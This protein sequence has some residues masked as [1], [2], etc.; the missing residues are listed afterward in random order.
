M[1]RKKVLSQAAKDIIL[2]NKES[3][4]RTIETAL[5]SKHE[6]LPRKA[7]KTFLKDSNIERFTYRDFD[8]K[9][10]ANYVGAW[11][12]DIIY[13]R[14]LIAKSAKERREQYPEDEYPR[15]FAIFMNT[16]SGYVFY[17][18]S[19][20]QTK[21]DLYSFEK[22][23]KH[24]LNQKF[25]KYPIVSVQSDKQSGFDNKKNYLGN[26]DVRKYKD[27]YHVIMS[28]INAFASQMRKYIYQAEGRFD[29]DN[30]PIKLSRFEEFVD[31]W[32]H[33][34]VPGMKCTRE[35][36]MK[37]E[38][39]EVLYIANALYG[40]IKQD[41]HIKENQITKD[42]VIQIKAP[43][44]PSLTR[45]KQQKTGEIVPGK[46]KL[47]S[48]DNN[49]ITIQNI[50]HPDNVQT[51]HRR[52]I[53]TVRRGAVDEEERLA[54]INRKGK[55][56]AEEEHRAKGVGNYIPKKPFKNKVD[57]AKWIYNAE[58][59]RWEDIGFPSNWNVEYRYKKLT[60]ILDKLEDTN[61]KNEIIGPVELTRIKKNKKKMQEILK[62][63][64]EQTDNP[65]PWPR[66]QQVDKTD[67]NNK[68]GR[69]L[70]RSMLKKMI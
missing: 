69:M 42:D 33:S 32:N 9:V 36:M 7:I 46:Y 31:K 29:P 58:Q 64:M 23:F 13:S 14:G 45:N 2:E 20:N 5:K 53:A 34:K 15:H 67:A 51:V 48:Q 49:L 39:L 18:A 60:E 30:D 16:N 37:D 6:K 65:Y 55:E 40:T 63:Y 68:S 61:K 11:L 70:T 1:P 27:D 12:F 10:F 24:D 66:E 22:Q 43:Y 57:E 38:K 25:P 50:E 8:K 35:E 62:N 59:K 47:V 54:A 4:I 52:N 17:Y 26:A 21:A 41:E 28:K 56:K 44:N 3:G 19:N